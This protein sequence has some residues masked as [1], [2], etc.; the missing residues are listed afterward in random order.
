MPHSD[1]VG[2]ITYQQKTLIER[3]L[4]EREDFG[5]IMFRDLLQGHVTLDELS[6]AEASE[7]IADLV[8]SD[9]PEP[10]VEEAEAHEDRSRSRTP[11]PATPNQIKYLNDLGQKKNI[12]V[13]GQID[14]ERLFERLTA[15]NASNL[16]DVF[17]YIPQAE[18][19]H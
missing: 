12:V 13:D 10:D 15:P 4:N 17:K 3:H 1:M 9:E 16:I 7:L 18:A 14:A 5:N 11:R 8:T 6:A 19:S 2:S